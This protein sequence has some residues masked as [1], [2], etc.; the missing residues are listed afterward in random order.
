MR[1]A[2]FVVV[3]A[4]GIVVTAFLIDELTVC[5]T[6]N[7]GDAFHVDVKAWPPGALRCTVEHPDG[8]TTVGTYVPWKQ[9]IAVAIAALGIAM[10]SPRRALVTLV[11]VVLGAGLWFF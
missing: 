7:E 6:L 5:P 8:G 9:W 11:L 3:L 4:I 1:L 2:A 10:F